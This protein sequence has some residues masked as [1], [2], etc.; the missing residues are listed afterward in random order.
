MSKTLTIAGLLLVQGLACQVLAA[1]AR[2]LT[3]ARM[4]TTIEAIRAEING[5]E[6]DLMQ[7]RENQVSAASQLKKI[8]RLMS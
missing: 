2:I 4:P 8:R 5:I 6:H 7:R 3:N 1:N